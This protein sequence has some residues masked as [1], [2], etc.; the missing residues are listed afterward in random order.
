MTT[1]EERKSKGICDRIECGYAKGVGIN[2]NVFGANAAIQHRTC[3]KISE[4]LSSQEC[5]RPSKELA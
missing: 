3:K 4:H 1:R 2:K 5:V